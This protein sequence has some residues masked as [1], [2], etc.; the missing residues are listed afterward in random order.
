M[1]EQRLVIDTDGSITFIY[2]DS[3]ID[4]FEEGTVSIKRV[5]HVEPDEGQWYASI[6]DGPILGPF[7]LRSQALDAEID[8]L[9]EKL[10]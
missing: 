4:L 2:D 6:I 10:F 8:Y 1:N 7:P 3:L 9:K 5:S